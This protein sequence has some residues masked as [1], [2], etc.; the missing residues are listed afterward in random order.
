MT[1][2]SKKIYTQQIASA[3]PTQIIALVFS[4]AEEYISD[5]V[6]AFD[7]DDFDLFSDNIR[8]A[9]KCVEDLTE[10]LDMKYEI[11]RNL[12]EIYSFINRELSLAI[13]K[14]NVDIVKRISSMLS[15]L[16]DAFAEL[17]K[18]DTSGAVMGNTQEVYAGL[19]YGK[20]TL[21]E[22]TNIQSNRGYTV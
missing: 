17:A 3:N 12:L 20:G 13:P 11:S 5:A 7:S 8:K 14:K 21:T 6:S 9:S 1:N 16:R 10:A 22:S 18:Q 2:E 15:K 19:T 4:I